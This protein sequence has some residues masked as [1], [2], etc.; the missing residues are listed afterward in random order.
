MR[1]AFHALALG[2]FGL[3]A[4][5]GAQDA[6]LIFGERTAALAMDAHCDLFTDRQRAA[7]DAA[8]LQARGA[9]LRS[10]IAP[11]QIQAYGAEIAAEARRRDCVSSEVLA[12]RDRVLT[13]FDGYLRVGN[14]T[15]PGIAFSWFANRQILT[16]EPV[17]ALLQDTGRIRV[18]IS[19]VEG[20]ISFTIALPN[21][22]NY[23][24]AVLV[25]R[26]MQSAPE[27]YDPT[28]GGMF[29]GPASA[30]WAQWTPPDYA[31]RLVWAS[32]QMNGPA[33]DALAGAPQGHV[34][35]FPPSVVQQLGRLDPRETARIDLMGRNG[36]RVASDYFEIGDFAAAV[37][38]L[39]AAI[40]DTSQIE[41]PES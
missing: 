21:G 24:S 14:M 19:R 31:R 2:L 38:F 30:S 8:R 7:L 10:G 15:F 29:A 27:L 40:S 33:A 3:T 5:A 22:G 39:R 32:D 4:A 25:T 35:R 23:I 36:E 20:D 13:A 41:L 37:A 34:F 1:C 18:G 16:D 28:M 26:N 17:W 6:D 11:D 9:L 12:M